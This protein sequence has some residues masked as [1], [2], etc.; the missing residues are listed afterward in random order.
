MTE[1]MNNSGTS[2]DGFVE[3]PAYQTPSSMRGA[4]NAENVL[5]VDFDGF[6]GTIDILLNL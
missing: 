1:D 5:E 3:G 4:T 6:E 2:A